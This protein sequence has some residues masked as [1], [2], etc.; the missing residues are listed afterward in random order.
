MNIESRIVLV[1]VTAPL[2]YACDSP[3]S[4]TRA[5]TRAPT[6]NV[7]NI[8]VTSY[9]GNIQVQ[10]ARF[11]SDPIAACVATQLADP[12]YQR[13]A[14]RASFR[15]NPGSDLAQT[16]S[17]SADLFAI[18]GES[19]LTIISGDSSSTVWKANIGS[20]P[21]FTKVCESATTTVYLDVLEITIPA[22]QTGLRGDSIQGAGSIT[23]NLRYGPL[24]WEVYEEK[25][26]VQVQFDLRR[27]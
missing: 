15:F 4:P 21:L 26:E 13:T 16:A 5:P 14:F 3:S 8:Q 22:S 24:A 11:S 17:W 10:S 2:L 23:V 1:L 25:T 7:G 27:Q 9:V 6:S 20:R 19:E 12:A 18:R